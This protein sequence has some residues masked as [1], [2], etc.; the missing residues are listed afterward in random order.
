VD[1]QFVFP[2]DTAGRPTVTSMGGRTLYGGG[3][4]VP[5][6]IAGAD[7][8]TADEQRAVRELFQEGGRFTTGVFDFAVQ[9]LRSR[10]GAGG[11]VANFGTPAGV[12]VGDAELAGLY[13]ALRAQEFGV[14]PGSWERARRFVKLQLETEI[15]LQAFG[16][17]GQFRARMPADRPLQEAL[18][19][20]RGAPSTA[21]LLGR[22]STTR[23]DDR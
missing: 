14:D 6:R 5:D 3:G 9:Y 23:T 15:A 16:E 2:P 19:L 21:A 11:T 22:V 18:E 13:A 20:L 10:E 12:Q 7:T 1:G 8:L 17:A 4:I